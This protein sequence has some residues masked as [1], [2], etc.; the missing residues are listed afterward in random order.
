MF[1]YK[2]ANCDP[3][4]LS[5]EVTEAEMLNR[6]PARAVDMPD[7]V[8][9]IPAGVATRSVTPQAAQPKAANLIPK[10]PVEPQVYLQAGNICVLRHIEFDKT[11]LLNW[12]RTLAH[13]LEAARSQGNLALVKLLEAEA[14]ES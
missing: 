5:L 3:K 1:S 2:Q 6:Q 10:F 8:R 11:Q 12:Q 14:A 13:R 9:H 7:Y 4:T